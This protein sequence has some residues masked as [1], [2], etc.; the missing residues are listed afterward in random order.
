MMRGKPP[1]RY[2]LAGLPGRLMED[3]VLL[4]RM[5]NDYIRGR[6]RRVPVRSIVVLIFALVYVLFPLDL[7]PDYLP[8]YG[9]ID[10]VVVV[11]GCLYFLEKDLYAYREWKNNGRGEDK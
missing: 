3:A 1:G 11:V 10:D 6:Y 9:Q 7:V 5:A 2:S 4:L 8:G